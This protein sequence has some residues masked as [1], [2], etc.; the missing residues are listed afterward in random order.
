MLLK[1]MA[2]KRSAIVPS[3]LTASAR[4]LNGLMSSMAVKRSAAVPFDI[5]ASARELNHLMVKYF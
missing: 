5:T 3:N 1:S 2:V 4:E